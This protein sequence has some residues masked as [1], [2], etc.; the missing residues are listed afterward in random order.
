MVATLSPEATNR[1][2]IARPMPR[3]AP[4]TSTLRGVREEPDVPAE[5]SVVVSVTRLLSSSG[6]LAVWRIV[7][8]RTVVGRHCVEA[9]RGTSPTLADGLA[10]GVARGRTPM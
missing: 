2:A 7:A 3:F 8:V 9:G 6:A 10:P 5:A 1:S 4:V